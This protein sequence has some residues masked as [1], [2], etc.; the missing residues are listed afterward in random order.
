VVSGNP[1]NAFWWVDAD[2]TLTTSAFQGTILGG[3]DITTTDTS[4]EG[5]LLA[6][7]AVTMTRTNIFGCSAAGTWLGTTATR[8][9][10]TAPRA[11]GSR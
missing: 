4:L 5:R 11:A 9:W 10:A 8:A 1:C 6:T 2:V 7:G 3:G